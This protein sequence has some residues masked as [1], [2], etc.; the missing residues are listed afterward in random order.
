MPEIIHWSSAAVGKASA[1]RSLSC[2]LTLSVANNRSRCSGQARERFRVRLLDRLGRRGAQK[3]RVALD[4]D[5][6]VATPRDAAGALRRAGRRSVVALPRVVAAENSVERD[7]G[8]APCRCNVHHD[9]ST[10]GVPA[11]REHWQIA[12]AGGGHCPTTGNRRR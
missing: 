3:L 7:H 2:A 9:S 11:A 5:L 12:I 10:N 4:G 8:R 1:G 6:I